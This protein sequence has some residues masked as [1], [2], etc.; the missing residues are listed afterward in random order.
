MDELNF[1]RTDQWTVSDGQHK[2]IFSPT[3][4]SKGASHA[5]EGDI[6]TSNN[7]GFKSA[8]TKMSNPY[9]SKQFSTKSAYVLVPDTK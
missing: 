6:L 7:H 1:R 4:M 3:F 9:T 2:T 5:R 8:S